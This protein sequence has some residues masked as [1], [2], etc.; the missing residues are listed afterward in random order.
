MRRKPTHEE[1]KQYLHRITSLE[2]HIVLPARIALLVS[3]VVLLW[4][5]IVARE[6]PILRAVK[7][8]TAAYGALTLAYWIYLFRIASRVRSPALTMGFVFASALSDYVF[9]GVLLS[10]AMSGAFAEPLGTGPEASLF[11]V[12]CALVVR[13][14]LLFPTP[15]LQTATS[16]LYVVGYVAALRLN[17]GELSESES[18]ELVFRVV[19]LMLVTICS[20]AIYSLTQRRRRELDDA[21]ERAIRSQRLDMAGILAAQVAHELKNPL[22]IMTNAA[23]LLRKA[24]DGLDPKMTRQVQII[25][26][27]INRADQIIRELLDYSKLAEGRIE[28]VLVNDSIG[29]SLDSLKHEIASRRIDVEKNYSLD[30]P[31]LFI[32]PGQLRQV[33][34]NLLLNACEAVESSG[35]IS[36]T[37]SYSAD[38]V[39]QV[40]IADTGKGM[41]AEVLSQ[42]FKPFFT[43]KEKGTGMGLSIA[44]NVMRAYGGEVAV[45]SEPG[46]GTT[47][48]LRFPTRMGKRLREPRARL[49]ADVHTSAA[50]VEP[51]GALRSS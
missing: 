18:R 30:L 40:S 49:R 27:E 48:H 23:Y 26:E 33:F 9:F 11:W 7:W 31:F 37:T 43:T 13:N 5:V 38:G 29:E 25:E 35:R 10:A 3:C 6:M 47:F 16:S 20:S 15:T 19:V 2:K 4:P 21:H 50:A 8:S 32:D 45:E 12:Y 24:K 51:K 44:H 28:A 17:L 41:D 36:V 34:H 1:R 14:T 42:L 39:I 46:K 22:S